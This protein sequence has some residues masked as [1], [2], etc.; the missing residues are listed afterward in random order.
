[1]VCLFILLSYFAG[2]QPTKGWPDWVDI[3][4]SLH[5]KMVYPPAD[6]NRVRRKATALKEANVYVLALSHSARRNKDK[7]TN[8]RDQKAD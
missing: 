6:D 4:G 5:T 8:K 2:T 7:R 1:M 3:G